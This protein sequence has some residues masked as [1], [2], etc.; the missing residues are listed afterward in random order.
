MKM[1][2]TLVLAAALVLPS[3]AMA[4]SLLLTCS[5]VDK[6]TIACESSYSNGKSAAGLFVVVTDDK[7]KELTK[8]TLDDK[9]MV[10]LKKPSGNFTVTVD[11]G[12]T[13]R[14]HT[15]S[16]KSSDIK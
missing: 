2:K 13:E 14:N 5:S 12:K 16:V 6:D 10:T 8:T 11:E 3:S 9:A 1:L 15:A 7:G 4:H